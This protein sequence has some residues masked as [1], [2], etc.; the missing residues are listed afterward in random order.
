MVWSVADFCRRKKPAPLIAT[1]SGF[2][3]L[4]ILP[5]ENCCITA[6]DAAPIPTWELPPI[7]SDA[8]YMSANCAE[9]PLKPTVEA[10]EMLLLITSSALDETFRPLRP[11]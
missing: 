11:C 10:L 9:A 7:P 5:W 2:V 8:A 6:G 4:E 3:E 1:S